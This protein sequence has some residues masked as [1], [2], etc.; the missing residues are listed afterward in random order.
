[1]PLLVSSRLR[2]SGP[3][4]FPRQTAKGNMPVSFQ[5]YPEFL[6]VP[7]DQVDLMLEQLD[8]PRAGFAGAEALKAAEIIRQ[9]RDAGPAAPDGASA[10]F[11]AR[12]GHALLAAID[13]VER[14]RNLP[15]ELTE[16]RTLLL[17]AF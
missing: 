10:Q 12:Y 13:D 15:P 16:L 4:V 5:I 6:T 17:Q 14:A 9:A 8:R 11:D 3:P 1:V 7:D 2:G